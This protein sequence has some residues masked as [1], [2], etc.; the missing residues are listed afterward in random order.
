MFI[1]TFEY[2][3]LVENIIILTFV[4]KQEAVGSFHK[5]GMMHQLVGQDVGKASIDF[6]INH[7]FLDFFR[8]I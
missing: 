6:I 8:F 4:N 5:T 2:V 7:Q 1:M 3:C